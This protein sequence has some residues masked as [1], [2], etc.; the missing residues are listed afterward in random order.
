MTRLKKILRTPPIDL[1]LLLQS[2][3]LL[4]FWRLALRTMPLRILSRHFGKRP[5]AKAEGDEDLIKRVRWAVI[6]AARHAPLEFVCFPQAIVAQSILRRGGVAST[7]YYGVAHT[8]EGNLEA[9]VWLVADG[10]NVVGAERA[11][12]FRVLKTFPDTGEQ[13]GEMASAFTR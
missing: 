4:A 6:A 8:T 5:T 9:H 10:V 11:A 3:F 1:A 2:F 7:M 12:N 13:T